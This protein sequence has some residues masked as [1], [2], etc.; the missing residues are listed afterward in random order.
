MSGAA[1]L[2]LFNSALKN[3]P[4]VGRQGGLGRSVSVFSAPL[5]LTMQAQTF[6][7]TLLGSLSRPLLKDPFE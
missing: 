4:D 7:N 2:G 6:I 5:G 3:R 1:A